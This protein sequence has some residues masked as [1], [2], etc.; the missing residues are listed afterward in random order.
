MHSTNCRLSEKSAQRWKLGDI[1]TLHSSSLQACF[2]SSLFKFSKV[3]TSK[4]L[5]WLDRETG[6]TTFVHRHNVA[7][8][9]DVFCV[10]NQHPR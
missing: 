8:T 5:S 4:P 2:L 6:E 9:D 7:I 3:K 1:S 10:A